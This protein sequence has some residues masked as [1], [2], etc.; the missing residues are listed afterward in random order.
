MGRGFQLFQQGMW[1]YISLTLG[2]FE[3]MIPRPHPDQLNH[4]VHS[5][6]KV[7]FENVLWGVSLRMIIV[8]LVAL[9]IEAGVGRR[10]QIFQ[11]IQE[12]G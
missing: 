4:N 5:L 3:K 12:L 7:L 6:K 10:G 9:L 11:E 2:S 1:L 8:G